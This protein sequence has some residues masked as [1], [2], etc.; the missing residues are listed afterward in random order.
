MNVIESIE[1]VVNEVN[2]KTLKRRKIRNLI[3][4]LRSNRVFDQYDKDRAP[5]IKMIFEPQF[6]EVDLGNGL[7]ETMN[8]ENFTFL[9]DID[10]N[11]PLKIVTT[12]EWVHAGGGYDKHGL[13]VPTAFTKQKM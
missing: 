6:R 9:W 3:H 8:W 7:K 2:I 1:M 5:G 10:P 13:C 12:K 4:R 11:F